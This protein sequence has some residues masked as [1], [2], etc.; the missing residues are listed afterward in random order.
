[1]NIEEVREFCLSVKGAEE[2]FPFD[3]TTL[4]FKVMGK[5]FAYMGLERH[6]SD[7]MVNLKCDPEKAVELRE[8]YDC[9][10]PGYHSNKKYW[11]SI[12]LEQGMPDE[13][14]KGWILHSVSEVIKGLPKKKQEEYKNLPDED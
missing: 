10:I 6:G 9:V 3:E 12:F 1:M 2:C 7:F 4:V 5:M 13:E 14:L 11:N 8:Q